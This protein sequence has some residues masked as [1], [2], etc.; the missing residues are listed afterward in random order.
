MTG[1]GTRLRTLWRR[2]PQLSLRWRVAV[3][4]GL[5]SV[6]VAAVIAIV[7]WRLASQYMIDQR[8]QRA[9][10]QAAVTAQTLRAAARESTDPLP[11]LLANLA[12]DPDSTILVGGDDGWVVEGR[13]IDPD[14]VPATLRAGG[15][16]ARWEMLNVD[17]SM[18]LA[19]TLASGIPASPVFVEVFQ[20]VEYD[21]TRQ[22]LILVF[23]GGVIASGLFGV[24]IGWWASRRAL[25]PLITLTRAAGRVASGDLGARLPDQGDPDLAPIA[26]A[27][28]RTATD[29]EQRVRQDARFAGDVSHE[30]R[31]PLTT[32]INAIEVL[33]HRRDAFEP[34]ARQAIDLLEAEVARF[35][36]MV[37]DL[38][39]ISRADQDAGDEHVE[40]V[41][42]GEL[43][44]RV[45][46]SIPGSP[47]P[48]I[49]SPA[50]LVRGD[51]RR[52]VRVL[53]NLLDNARRHAGGATRVAIFC[54]G[55][56]A[57][58]EVDDR[59]PG[60]RSEYR[61]Q[62]FE[63]FTRIR[64]NADH[65]DEGG[66]GL[67]LALVARHVGRHHGA[68]WVEDRP[69]GGARFVVEIPCVPLSSGADR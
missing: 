62:V 14:R 11:D 40:L 58:I 9:T 42:L 57:R 47:T 53:A 26:V 7:T 29:L 5:A 48:E 8:V 25:R 67:G 23:V 41:D 64:G 32:M 10:L 13:A 12:T 3:T 55:P 56:M 66:S 52:L 18:V 22:F 16:D 21:R 43:A 35:R 31:S 39:E 51:R 45:T 49:A 6:A 59:G 65:T 63:R 60:V 44:R 1:A 69:G 33:G 4:F 24:A 19:V 34:T 2:R 50:P 30:L 15:P 37:V 38:L 20:L 61:Q 27:F 36:I 68:V 54:R 17:G 28:N 46:G